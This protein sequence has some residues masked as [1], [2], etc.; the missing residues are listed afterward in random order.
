MEKTLFKSSVLFLFSMLLFLPIGAHAEDSGELISK[1]EGSSNVS[2]IE[3]APDIK[4]TDFEIEEGLKA[5]LRK[6]VEAAVAKLAVNDGFKENSAVKIEMPKSLKNVKR[7]LDDMGS[8]GLAKKYVLRLNRAAEQSSPK[9]GGYFIVAINQ[10]RI[11]EPAKILAGGNKSA[12]DYL[13]KR[14]HFGLSKVLRPIIIKDMKNSGVY[15][16]YDEMIGIYRRVPY[17]PNVRSGAESYMVDKILDAFFLYIGEE[18]RLIRENADK[19][20]EESIKKLFP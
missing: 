6:G 13:K 8:E 15:R 20:T 19:R 16:M 5:I 2:G 14:M 10:F 18:E 11:K 7:V 9:V 17:E 12:T 3:K 4:L 1:E